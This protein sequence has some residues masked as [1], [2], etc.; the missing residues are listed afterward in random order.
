MLNYHGPNDEEGIRLF[1]DGTEVKNDLV[2]GVGSQ[3]AQG[4]GRVV[5]GRHYTDSD[6]EY[7]S[8]MID[9]LRYFNQFLREDEI[10][11]LGS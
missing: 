9:E 7:M 8:L 10:N 11:L 6:V 5:V 3:P 1:Y 2:V 4:D